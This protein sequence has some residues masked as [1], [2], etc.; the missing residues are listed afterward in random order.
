MFPTFRLL[1]AA[2]FASIVALT[3]GF[4]VFAAFGVNHE[5]L[6]RMP[7][8]TA[9]LQL[10]ADETAS[11]S[12]A[13]PADGGLPYRPQPQRPSEAQA[14]GMEVSAPPVTPVRLDAV[15]LPHPGPTEAAKTEKPAPAAHD[16]EA[17]SVA[18]PVVEA[19]PAASLP[20]AVT[21]PPSPAAPPPAPIKP[22]APVAVSVAAPPANT[23]P[24]VLIKPST[25]VGVS[26]AVPP[27]NAPPPAPIKLPAPLAVSV[28]A[29]PANTPPAATSISAPPVAARPATAVAAH[30]S[31]KNPEAVKKAA[32]PAVAAIAPPT[33]EHPAA[34]GGAVRQILPPQA[35]SPAKVVGKPGRRAAGKLEPKSVERR[36]VTLKRRQIRRV[37]AYAG[38]RFGPDSSYEEPVFQSA[39]GYQRQSQDSRSYGAAAGWSDG[40]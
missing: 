31:V 12:P 38:T 16:R 11:G 21:P 40:Y 33:V 14:G 15:D 29:P 22:S 5:P 9:P 10:V 7:P 6:S 36:R 39:P 24:S 19:S 25:S 13:S 37:P 23:P 30:A 1:I 4:A 20:V 28:A 26:V 18:S 34:I 2:T 27:A 8:N 17:V 32:N 3:C 35:K